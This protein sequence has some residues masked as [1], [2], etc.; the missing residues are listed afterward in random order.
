LKLLG[1]PTVL[2]DADAMRNKSGSEPITVAGQA[3]PLEDLL[4]A[5]DL[6][7]ENT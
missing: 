1:E 7:Q 2:E 6:S 3:L 4:K 5:L